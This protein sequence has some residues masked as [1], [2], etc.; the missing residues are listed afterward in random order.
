MFESVPVGL[1]NVPAPHVTQRVPELLTNTRHFSTA[2]KILKRP[3]DVTALSG[4][5]VVFE[6]GISED[7]IPVKWMFNNTE[8][9]SDEHYNILSE[10]KNHKL[11]VHDA[12]DSKQGEYTAVIGHLQCSAHLTVEC[13]YHHMKH[14]H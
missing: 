12:D 7:D 3:K 8:L 6:V 4:A 11:I 5:T 9:Q 1:G 14:E 2:I 13:E 10:K